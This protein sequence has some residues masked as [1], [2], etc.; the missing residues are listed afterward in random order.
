MQSFW[1]SSLMHAGSLSWHIGTREQTGAIVNVISNTCAF[2]LMASLLW[3]WYFLLKGKEILKQH[4]QNRRTWQGN[5]PQV[6]QIDSISIHSVT[7]CVVHQ[8]AQREHLALRSHWPQSAASCWIIY[9][10]YT[11]THHTLVHILHLSQSVTPTPSHTNQPHIYNRPLQLWSTHTHWPF[12]L[13]SAGHDSD[14][15]GPGLP[16]LHCVPG[17]L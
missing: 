9:Y 11:H 10:N 1:G 14:H 5:Y 15:P 12:V 16:R 7:T 13:F 4:A 6:T 3:K 2:H 17:G 8:V